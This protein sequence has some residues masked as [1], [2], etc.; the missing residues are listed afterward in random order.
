MGSMWFI[1]HHFFVVA[2]TCLAGIV[3]YANLVL[4]GILLQQPHLDNQW[5]AIAFANLP[6]LSI[7][8]YNQH[9]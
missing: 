2:F 3:Q 4:I 6:T 9:R 7:F 1:L 8:V 5:Y